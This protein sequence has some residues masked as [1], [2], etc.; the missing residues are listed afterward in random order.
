MVKHNTA[1][2]H[3][4]KRNQHRARLEVEALDDRLLLAVISSVDEFG[5]LTVTTNAGD[6]VKIECY[7]GQVK[8]N[9]DPADPFSGDPTSGPAACDDITAMDVTGDALANNFDLSAVTA[10]QFPRM[11]GRAVVHIYGGFGDDTIQGSQ[12]GDHI[13]GEGGDDSIEGGG[14]G[15]AISGAGGNDEI[16]G[17]DN[18]DEISG[19]YG[20]DTLYGE[21][22]DDHIQGGYDNDLLDGGDGEDLLWGE[23]GR[24]E[25]R[26]G[27]G[28]DWLSGGDDGFRD[29]VLGGSDSGW[30]IGYGV[31]F[32]DEDNYQQIEERQYS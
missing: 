14:G 31:G 5:T 29:F 17:G 15:D 30:D 21:G 6:S 16:N 25:L 12:L 7:F 19:G 2:D 32:P 24:D 22:G 23:D 3:S 20:L 28:S 13:F 8:I 27:D 9:R 18:G 11:D 10:L 26:G 1:G 4:R